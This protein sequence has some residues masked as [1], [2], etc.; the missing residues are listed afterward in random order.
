MTVYNKILVP[1][2]NSRP[3][4]TALDHAIRI[5]KMSASYSAN[6]NINVI[7]LYVV[8]NIP[9][10]ATFGAGIFK[11]NK[12]GDKLTLEQ[13]LKDIT[14]EVKMEA[15]KMLKEKTKKYG[16]IE[17]VSLESKVII[18]DPTNEII[19]FANDKKVDLIIMGTTGL[20]GIKKFK[21]LGSVAR[22]VS[23]KAKC[24]VMLIR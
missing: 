5:A 8:Q 20:A 11:S 2:D 7:L 17:N 15:K 23:E 3:S 22:N 24:P 18:G 16:N 19:E 13:Y 6:N 1:Y 12:T 9:V 14:I 10:P 21:A 4:D